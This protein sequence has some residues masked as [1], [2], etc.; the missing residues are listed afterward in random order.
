[1][2]IDFINIPLAKHCAAAPTKAP[3]V[4]A[5]VT[6]KTGIITAAASGRLKAG[7]NG[8]YA[9]I[10]RSVQPGKKGW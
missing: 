10:N 6:A 1:M 8:L 4:Q 2:G 5:L 9:T 3:K 7:L